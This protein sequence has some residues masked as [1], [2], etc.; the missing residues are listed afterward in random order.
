MQKFFIDG[1]LGIGDNIMQRPFIKKMVEKGNEVW[2]KTATPEIYIDIPGIHFVKS[3]T[4]LR[5]Q[6]RNEEASGVA[7][8]A[9]PEDHLIIRKKIFY[10]TVELSR[11]SVFD[12]G[13]R[14]FGIEPTRLDLPSFT[15]PDIGIPTNNKV[16]LIRPTT[17]R[18]EWHNAARGPLNGHVDQASRY[19]AQLGYFCISVADL[20]PGVE[21][22][23]DNEPFAHLKLHGGQLKLTEL[24]ALVE[25]SDVVVTGSGLI[26]QMAFAY[27][28]H[29]IFLG[30]DCGG[31]NHHT[32]ITDGRLMDLSRCLFLYPDDYCMCQQMKHSC[33]K[34]ISDLPEKL[35]RWMHEKNL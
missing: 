8:E 1:M 7:W 35:S 30:G 21:W 20:Q 15:L 9:L 11:G 28:R 24:M 34:H 25:R 19:L 3:G 18:R 6:H 33:N 13:R 16:A 23:P 2:I 4:S 10:G 26:S 12:A 31:C 29:T 27:R 17:E 32:K 14:Q 22:I 5:T